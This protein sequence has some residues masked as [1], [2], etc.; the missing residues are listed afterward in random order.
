MALFSDSDRKELENSP[1]VFKVTGSNVT[2]TSK[3]KINAVKTYLNGK[4]P[5]EIFREGGINLGLFEE[6]YAKRAL[7]RWRKIYSEAGPQ[8]LKA[9]RRGSGATGRPPGKKFSSQEDELRYLR[10]E[11]DFLKKLRALAKNYQKKKD[12]P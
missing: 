9:E 8:G 7:A 1:H 12:S 11:N 3:F 6:S 2:Y 10:S 5:K 4:S